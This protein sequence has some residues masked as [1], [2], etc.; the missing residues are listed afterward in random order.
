MSSEIRTEA[1]PDEIK[2]CNRLR[3]LLKQMPT[4]MKLFADGELKAVDANCD[5]ETSGFQSFWNITTLAKCD[6]GDPWQ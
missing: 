5:C 4:S 1:T 2:F 6:G 3:R